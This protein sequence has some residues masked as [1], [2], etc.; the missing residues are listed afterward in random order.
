MQQELKPER[1]S[2]YFFGIFLQYLI[3]ILV[4]K[5]FPNMNPRLKYI[6]FKQT[7]NNLPVHFLYHTIKFQ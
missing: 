5:I 7:F 4:S 2:T 3:F 6:G 1:I